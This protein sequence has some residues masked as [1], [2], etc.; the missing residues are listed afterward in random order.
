MVAITRKMNDIKNQLSSQ[1]YSANNKFNELSMNQRL[2]F[3]LGFLFVL[4]LMKKVY[5]KLFKGEKKKYV[6]S[7]FNDG[8]NAKNSP[9]Y[10]SSPNLN[11]SGEGGQFTYTI[12]LYLSDWYSTYG[13]WK[14]IFRKGNRSKK[15]LTKWCSYS[16][17]APG[18]YFCDKKNDIRVVMTTNTEDG[19]Q[20][21]YCDIHNVPIK[22]WFF[23]ALVI[24]NN[25][26]AI[27]RN[28]LLERTCVYKGSIKNNNGPLN[29]T[30]P[31]G[32]NGMLSNLTYYNSALD[33][34]DIQLICKTRGYGKKGGEI[35]SS[36]NVN[37]EPITHINNT[38]DKIF[39]NERDD[40]VCKSKY[41]K[42]F[43]PEIE[44]NCKGENQPIGDGSCNNQ[45]YQFDFKYYQ[46]DIG[47]FNDESEAR[48][49]IE[50]QQENNCP[51]INGDNDEDEF[52]CPSEYPYKIA[53]GFPNSKYKICY[54]SKAYANQG[55]GTCNS[56]CAPQET[57]NQVKKANKKWGCRNV[58]LCK[59]EENECRA[60]PG[61]LGPFGTGGPN[62]WKKGKTYYETCYD[63]DT[64][65]GNTIPRIGKYKCNYGNEKPICDNEN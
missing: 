50:T 57:Y 59:N 6:V 46:K 44:G 1:V 18:M 51:G 23:I 14:T 31:N 10:F 9:V 37:S 54:N 28:C 24:D 8:K 53:Q 39:D 13:T 5:N 61:A 36:N 40:D 41:Y 29:V 56:F 42:K 43:T 32:Y 19:I 63:T 12:W 3:I 27:Y 48:D 22:K 58:E 20:L 11:N 21:E 30:T 65:Q 15:D 26:M 2:V 52:E 4:Y 35:C 60:N 38:F 49:E 17:Q 62:T 7:Y 55:S 25:T 45:C 33:P 64:R 34:S 16:D 47:C